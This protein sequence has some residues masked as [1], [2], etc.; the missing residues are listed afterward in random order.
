MVNM[1][2][3]YALLYMAIAVLFVSFFTP[4][5]RVKANAADTYY[6]SLDDYD[7]VLTDE[8][9][10]D[11]LEL[12]QNAAD[13][14]HYNIGVVITDELG[15]RTDRE[16]A[17]YYLDINFGRT[18]DSVV[19]MI[20]NTHG[21]A[22]YNS[23]T[24]RIS[25]CGKPERKLQDKVETVFNNF[26][27]TL[28]K[29][30]YAAAFGTFANDVVNYSGNGTSDLSE[31]ADGYRAVLDDLDECLT[32]IEETGL[33]K[34]MREAAEDANCHIGIIITND[35]EGKSDRKF[36]DDYLDQTFGTGSTAVVLMLLN[37]HGNPAYENYTD[38][39]STSGEGRD[40]Y[41]ANIN[42]MFDMVYDKLEKSD[43]SFDFYNGCLQFCEAAKRYGN[44]S[45]SYS[46][47]YDSSERLS[48]MEI[49]F[50]LLLFALIFALVLALVIVSITA[51]GYKKKKKLSA[52]AYLNNSNTKI[53]NSIDNFIREYTTVVRL[54]SSSSGGG[55][56]GGGGGGHHSGG[57]GGGGGHHR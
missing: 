22:A 12:L 29:S 4:P 5:L 55:H 26:Y 20:L 54:S 40:K 45:G 41:D 17:E 6:A 47:Q 36:A 56:H 19:L 32:P 53:T 13:S 37:S 43:G 51:G 8:E 48:Y 11:V 16:Y 57:H 38:R 14:A 24:D 23:Y 33:L 15:G 27:D 35:L 3:K 1:K 50:S 9:E 42:K 30:G 49:N 7:D 2:I 10:A 28:G 21:K 39:I 52:A 31:T 44:K 25:L 34:A 18:G 46:V